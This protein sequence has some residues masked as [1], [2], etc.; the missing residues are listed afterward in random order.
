MASKG[1]RNITGWLLDVYP[2]PERGSLLWVL[3]D[4]NQ[5]H[6]L[7]QL[8][9]VLFYVQADQRRLAQFSAALKGRFGSQVTMA[10]STRL[11]LFAGEIEVM[12]VHTANSASQ[13]KVFY[14]AYRHFPELL[15]FDV[16]VPFAL[17]FAARYGT[18]PLTRC[19]MEVRGTQVCKIDADSGLDTHIP[20]FRLLQLTPDVDPEYVDPN[21]VVARFGNEEIILSLSSMPEFLQQMDELLLGYDPDIIL[22]KWGDTWLLPYLLEYSEAQEATLHLNRTSSQ[23]V[24]RRKAFSY[25]T[26][27]RV[28]HRGQQV[29]LIGRWHID[30][31]NAVMY[32]E[33]ELAG[34][35][36]QARIT[37]LPVQEVARKSPGAG[38]TAMQMITAMRK[39]ILVPYHKSQVESFK[40]PA[41][42]IA[43]DRGGLVGQPQIGIHHNVAGIDFFSMYPQIM[44][45]YNISPEVLQLTEDESTIPVPG[46]DAAIN[47]HHTGLV[48]KTLQALLERRNALKDKLRGMPK[49]DHR[50]TEVKA[51][52]NA[53][54]WLLVVCFG[55]L[56]HKHF[57]WMKIEAHEAVTALGRDLLLQAKETAEQNGFRVLYFNVDG[58]YVQKEGAA[59]E[60]DFTELLEAIQNK[61]GLQIGLDG[62]FRWIAFL[63]SRI[64]SRRPV[65]NRYFG[66]FRNGDLKVRGVE[67]RRHDTPP[68]IFN[69]Q[70]RLLQLLATVPDGWPL[71]SSLPDMVKYL[72][73][74]ANDLRSGNILLE[75]L[76][77]SQRLSRDLSE[78][79]QPSPAAR[80]AAQLASMDKPMS[81]GQVVHF[82]Y[83]KGDAG[84]LAWRA[85][86]PFSYQS[87][88]VEMYL[89]LLVRAAS[90]VVM[91]LGIDESM[92]ARKVGLG[93]QMCL[94]EWAEEQRDYP[95]AL[96]IEREELS[97]I[98]ELPLQ[99]FVYSRENL[100]Q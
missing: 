15:Y 45:R 17:R 46:T 16:D 30:Q 63:P 99:E 34:I 64:D 77:V 76:L 23:S 51:R 69:A 44:A 96:P 5:R 4:D 11:D 1:L 89:K 94:L 12:A 95:L 67:I 79:R 75:D 21:R 37:G 36:E 33:Y 58:L 40:S 52:S 7:H 87:I 19:R 62:I 22:S 97:V 85:G 48:G 47:Q 73:E 49:G 55:Y 31:T 92:L 41:Q 88:D 38:I 28:L 54:K 66:V 82:L 9:E 8:F 57:R 83:V 6:L 35:L 18:R 42:L 71:E 32:G 24:Q 13:R 74:I 39:G 10:M 90:N 86:L 91:L 2:D 93:G 59:A 56:G 3:D 14:W 72:K 100:K 80:A 98:A 70:T 53:L 26:Y 81:A 50:Y 29:H 65:A 20:S 43:S 68:F 25:H 60:G 27:G 78:Y 84:V 61:T